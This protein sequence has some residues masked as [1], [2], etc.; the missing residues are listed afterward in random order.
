MV[1]MEMVDTKTFLD[2]IGAI[3]GK[4]TSIRPQRQTSAQEYG[5]S[6]CK[7]LIVTIFYQ[8]R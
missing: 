7:I 2:H 3:P 8:C 4:C 1:E 6:K 5:R